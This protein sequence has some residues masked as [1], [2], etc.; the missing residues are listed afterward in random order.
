MC[1]IYAEKSVSDVSFQL[2]RSY[3]VQK[4]EETFYCRNKHADYRLLQPAVPCIFHH[5][6]LN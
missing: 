5:T 6:L 1:H 2:L 4:P 3:N